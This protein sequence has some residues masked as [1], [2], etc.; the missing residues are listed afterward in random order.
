MTPVKQQ[1]SVC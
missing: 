1:M